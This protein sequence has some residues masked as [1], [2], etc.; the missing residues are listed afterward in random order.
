MPNADVVRQQ[1]EV[2]ASD[3]V[4]AAAAYWH[5][6]IQWRAVEGAA[7]DVGVMHGAE[8]LRRYYE[9]WLETF[10][11]LRADVVEVLFDEGEKVAL[12]LR[13]FGRGRVSGVETRGSYY[14]ACTVKDGRILSGREYD[15]REKALEA[16]S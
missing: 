3:G 16:V 6:D 13:N 10:E 9:D 15:S 2:L 8:R 7:D 11:D 1:F 4:D 14:V 5:P 12:R